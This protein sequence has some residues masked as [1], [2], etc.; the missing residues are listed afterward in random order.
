MRFRIEKRHAEKAAKIA[1]AFNTE[2]ICDNNFGQG[3]T[4]KRVQPTGWYFL[5]T[6]A[7]RG[8]VE[9]VPIRLNMHAR[10]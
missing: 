6:R 7:S 10:N 9:C 2:A 5:D 3:D 1:T 4:P 8:I